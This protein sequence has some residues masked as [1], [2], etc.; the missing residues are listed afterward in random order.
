MKEMNQMCLV[1]IIHITRANPF[2]ALLGPGG[3]WSHF[4]LWVW[5]IFLKSG[6]PSRA[7]ARKRCQG[8]FQSVI[9]EW[10]T[11]KLLKEQCNGIYWSVRLGSLKELGA[12]SQLISILVGAAVFHSPRCL[13]ATAPSACHLSAGALVLLQMV[14][15]TGLC[16][17]Q[18]MLQ[19]D[20]SLL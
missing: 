19:E 4:H 1:W 12:S 7:A 20:L 16:P 2:Q 8:G 6:D 14:Y 5:Q 11:S 3:A 9:I 18:R 10:N 13:C 17:C 15:T